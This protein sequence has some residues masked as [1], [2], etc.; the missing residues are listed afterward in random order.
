MFHETA[1]AWA[2]DAYRRKIRKDA[3]R[4]AAARILA[5]RR[6]QRRKDAAA[7]R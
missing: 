1:I 3:E 2:N 6:R 7:R 5:R 4:D